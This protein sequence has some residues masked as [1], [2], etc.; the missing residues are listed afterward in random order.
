MAR[1]DAVAKNQ[2]RLLDR[3]E[4]NQQDLW[5]RQETPRATEKASRSLQERIANPLE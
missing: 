3:L 4:A 5:S 1:L 2:A